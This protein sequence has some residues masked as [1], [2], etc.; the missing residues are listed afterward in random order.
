MPKLL[1]VE[2]DNSIRQLF[3][4]LATAEGWDVAEFADAEE[5]L[6]FLERNTADAIILDVWLPEMSGLDAARAIR[7]KSITAPI[8]LATAGNVQSIADEAAKIENLILRDKWLTP[9]E[10]R[11]ALR[12]ARTTGVFC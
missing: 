2:D 6:R 3:C 8:L 4:M 11:N 10:F 9:D 1:I 5:A 7:D 12:S